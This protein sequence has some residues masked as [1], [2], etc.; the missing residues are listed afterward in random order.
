MSL[1]QLWK[2]SFSD[3]KYRIGLHILF[4]IVYFILFNSFAMVLISTTSKGNERLFAILLLSLLFN[5]P[6]ICISYYTTIGTF[7][8]LIIKRQS[9]L[10]AFLCLIGCI[11]LFI[12]LMLL[13]GWGCI[14]AGELLNLDMASS[15]RP[16]EMA[17]KKYGVKTLLMPFVW[18]QLILSYFVLMAVPVGARVVRDQLRLQERKNFLEKENIKL[19]MNFLKAQIHPHFLFNTLNNIYSLISH[20][21]LE[22]SAEMVSGLS[23]LLRYAL[24]EGKSEFISLEKEAGMLKDY[25]E[26]EEVRTDDVDLEIHIPPRLPDLKIPPFLLL[27]LV[28]NAFKHGVNSQLQQACLKIDLQLTDVELE[29]TVQNTFDVDYRKKNSGG[30]GLLNLKKRLDYYYNDNYYLE[31]VENKNIFIAK[32]KLPLLCPL[33]NV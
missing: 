32:L 20:K 26:L 18:L 33:S 25:I 17:I 8:R 13:G 12:I 31:T 15:G 19:E 30:L 4:W 22:K 6:I 10:L 27:P 14:K 11:L 1:Q 23:S 29:L 7:Y 3:G 24:Y 16:F 5:V 28:E 9:Y 2:R 21:E